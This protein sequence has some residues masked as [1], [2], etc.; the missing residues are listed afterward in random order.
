[1]QAELPSLRCWLLHK[2][3]PHTYTQHK[4]AHTNTLMQLSP[5]DKLAVHR[6]ICRRAHAQCNEST[7]VQKYS[8]CAHT[9]TYA[10]AY[11]HTH[12][13][14]APCIC[15]VVFFFFPAVVSLAGLEESAAPG[16]GR[17]RWLTAESLEVEEPLKQCCFFLSHP[18]RQH[19]QPQQPAH[20]H[21]Q[22]PQGKISTWLLECTRVHLSTKMLNCKSWFLF[23]SE[24]TIRNT[25]EISVFKVFGLCAD[26]IVVF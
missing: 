7:G 17:A 24:E 6:C 8:A 5:S 11:L 13:P 9:Y 10:H 1:M 16:E 25:L 20:F 4:S 18:D 23:Y 15:L 2:S 21:L 19:S 26:C 22:T 3:A 12:W 14:A